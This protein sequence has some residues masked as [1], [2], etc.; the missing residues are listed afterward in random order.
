MARE[1]CKG[2][3]ISYGLMTVIPPF[4]LIEISC[5]TGNIRSGVTSAERITAV[6]QAKCSTMDKFD[7]TR[8]RAIATGRALKAL[9]MKLRGK[10]IPG[11]QVYMG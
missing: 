5:W 7:L 11:H 9:D 3:K 6:G 4:V 8:G 2:H 10:E 1:F